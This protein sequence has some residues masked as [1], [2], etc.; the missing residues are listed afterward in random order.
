MVGYVGPDELLAA[1]RAVSRGGRA[2]RC[3]VSAFDVGVGVT[4]G[5]WSSALP[6]Q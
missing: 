1:M 5:L 3:R 6:A 2:G 4:G